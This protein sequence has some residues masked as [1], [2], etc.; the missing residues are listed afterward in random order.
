MVPLKIVRRLSLRSIIHHILIIFIRPNTEY[1]NIYALLQYG[2]H[3]EANANDEVS[4]GK[5]CF[6]QLSR[7]NAT[8][9]RNHAATKDE[10]KAAQSPRMHAPQEYARI[11]LELE[12]HLW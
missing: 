4:F 1:F 5:H 8:A 10:E 9:T 2:Q 11:Q 7:E 12:F 6:Y 3:C